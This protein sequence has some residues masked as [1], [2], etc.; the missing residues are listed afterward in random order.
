MDLLDPRE[1]VN[2]WTH[3]LGVVLALPATCALWKRTHRT[4]RARW[5]MLVYGSSLA[6]CYTASALVHGLRLPAEQ[7]GLFDR[8]DRFGIYVLIA[9]TYTPFAGTLLEGKWRVG[10]LLSVWIITAAAGLALVMHGVF[11]PLINTLL[12]LAMGWGSVF[13]LAQAARVVPARKMWTL[14]AGGLFYSVGAFVNFLNGPS[15]WAGDL[16]AHELFH[17]LVLAGSAAHFSFMLRVVAPF[18]QNS[19]ACGGVPRGHV[20][21]SRSHASHPMTHLVRDDRRSPTP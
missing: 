21:F 16:A 2:T 19:I 4:R 18:A 14:V 3:A 13:C 10:T 7:L 1:P 8:L 11:P 12:Y 9:G 5:G 6:F 15:L 20:R 17:L